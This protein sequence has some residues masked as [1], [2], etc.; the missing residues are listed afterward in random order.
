MA[1]A[2]TNRRST[3]QGKL[4]ARER[5]ALLFDEGSLWKWI[6]S[7]TTDAIT[8]IWPRQAPD[9]VVTGYGTVDGRLVFAFAQD[10][11][12]LGGSWENIMRKKS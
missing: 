5:I 3:C 4:T 8:S 6:L 12:V 11:T 7:C 10:F 1:A 2:E 9:G